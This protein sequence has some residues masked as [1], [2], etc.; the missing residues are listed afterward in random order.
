MVEPRVSRQKYVPVR[1][2][3]VWA[4]KPSSEEGIVYVWM[5][6]C[7]SSSRVRSQLS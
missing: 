6:F 5:A 2:P 7:A 3:I 4:V 1:S